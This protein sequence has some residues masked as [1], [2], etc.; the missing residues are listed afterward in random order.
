M[1]DEEI[2][3]KQSWND[4]AEEWHVQVGHEGDD[5]RRQNSD[6]VLWRVLG[7]V[8]AKKVL[9]AGCGTGRLS[10]MLA[11]RGAK[12]VGVDTIY[13]GSPCGRTKQEKIWRERFP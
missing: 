9:D 7:S 4:K 5:N 11:R 3:V 1:D 8:D 6:P 13:W 10:R 2:E 12:V